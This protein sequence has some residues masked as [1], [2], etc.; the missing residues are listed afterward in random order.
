ML[1]KTCSRG[2]KVAYKNA[3]IY[4]SYII[5]NR[6]NPKQIVFLIFLTKYYFQP[7]DIT[8]VIQISAILGLTFVMVNDIFF[9]M[10]LLSPSHGEGDC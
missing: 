1:A 4:R 7:E 8:T 3:L 5:G 2:L 6:S 9:S 10:N